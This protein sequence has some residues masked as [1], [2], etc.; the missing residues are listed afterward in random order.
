[1]SSSLKLENIGCLVTKGDD[2]IKYNQNTSLLIEQDRIISIGSGTGD[3]IIDCKGKMVTPGFVD[4]HT[5]PIFFDLRSKEHQLRLL[6]ATYE[7]IAESG[8]GIVSS[9]KSVREATEKQLYSK[10]LPRIDRFLSLGTTT[11]EAKSGYGLDIESELKSLKI[12][13]SINQ[14]HKIDIIPTFMG[15]HAFPN[16]FSDDKEAYVCL[17][18]TS[19]SPR[20]GLLSRMPS[21]A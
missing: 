11:I 1:M 9:V 5:H 14:K 12:I 21:S 10:S 18:Y 3:R 6:G 16:K 4:S 17:L 7:E 13:D 20:D 2:G 19:P 8:G 15:A